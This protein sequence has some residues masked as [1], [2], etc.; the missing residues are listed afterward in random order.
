[1][2][3]IFAPALEQWATSALQSI[4]APLADAQVV[5]H[6]LV[7]T[8]L[9]GIDSHG[10]S[11]LPHYLN[12]IRSGSIQTRPQMQWEQSGAATGSVDGGDGLGIVACILATEKAIALA[13][14]AGAGVVGIKNS[15][16]CGA[17]G[18]YVRQIAAAG[19]VGI[20]FTHSDSFVVPHGGKKAF[21]GTNP[22]AIAVPTLDAARPLCVDTATSI[23]AWNRIMNARAAGVEVPTG[24]GVDENGDDSTD[25]QQIVAVKPMAGHKGFALA[26]LIDMLCGPLNGM[27]FGPHI[28]KMYFELEKPR[29]LGSLIIALD[30]ER[31]GGREFLSAMAE[32]CIGEVKTQGAEVLYPGEPEVESQSRRRESGIPLDDSLVADFARWA[33]E[34]GIEPPTYQGAPAL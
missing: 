30:A 3:T 24:W 28:P 29:K 25:P 1:M 32:Q 16:H 26:F 22:I 9:W 5:A 31:F 18:L 19:L 2:K 8:N 10:V 33:Q 21:F 7:Q 12:R 14:N 6:A 27:P 4:G 13:Q 34:L 20:A 17:M 23:V 15:S 11:R